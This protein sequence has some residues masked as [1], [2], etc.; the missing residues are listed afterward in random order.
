VDAVQGGWKAILYAN[1][2]LIDPQTSYNF[3]ADPEF[4]MQLDGGASR[5]WNLAYTAA[6]LNANSVAAVEMDQGIANYSQIVGAP[7]PV[8]GQPEE[9]SGEGMMSEGVSAPTSTSSARAQASAVS[10]HI[11]PTPVLPV[12]TSNTQPEPTIPAPAA[13]SFT[14]LEPAIPTPAPTSTTQPPSSTASA[15]F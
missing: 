3:F 8:E 11:M 13:T 12:T 9:G 1:L 6:L 7:A 10:D 4:N 2:A 15:Q 14:P 5:T